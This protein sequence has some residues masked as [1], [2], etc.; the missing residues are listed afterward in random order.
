MQPLVLVSDK[1]PEVELSQM[2][3]LSRT[4]LALVLSDPLTD[5]EASTAVGLNVNEMA[6]MS[7]SGDGDVSEVEMDEEDIE[8]WEADLDEGVQDTKSHIRDWAD[9]QKEIKAHLRKNSKTLPL[10]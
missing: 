4:R 9:L 8:D 6:A 7:K 10:S 1:Q 3:R 2:A 5:G